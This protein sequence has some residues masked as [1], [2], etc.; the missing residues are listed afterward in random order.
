MIA[1]FPCPSISF[2][3][4]SEATWLFTTAFSGLF[5]LLLFTL[6]WGEIFHLFLSFSLSLTTTHASSLSH[7]KIQHLPEQGYF[8]ILLHEYNLYSYLPLHMYLQGFLLQLTRP[9]WPGDDRYLN[10]LNYYPPLYK[11][12]IPSLYSSL[13]LQSDMHLGYYRQS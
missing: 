12:V 1:G 13:C 7:D 8:Y 9:T 10:S 2:F 6:Y 5:Q 4:V 3:V 11:F